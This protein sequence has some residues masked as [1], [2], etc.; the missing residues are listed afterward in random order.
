MIEEIRRFIDGRRS[1]LLHRIIDSVAARWYIEAGEIK[2]AK[3][4]ISSLPIESPSGVLL[5]ARLDLACG[6]PEAATGRLASTDFAN[7]RDRLTCELI[8]ARAAFESGRPSAV[9][10]M[11]TAV[12]LAVSEGFVKVFLEEGPIGTGL[13]RAAAGP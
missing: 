13:A 9:H 7:L 12:E 5:A 10:H 4:L 3:E 2:Q 6:R 8:L 11:A 1:A